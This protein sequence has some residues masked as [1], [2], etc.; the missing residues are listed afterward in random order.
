M[1]GAERWGGGGGCVC[2]CAGGGGSGD[3][4]KAGHRLGFFCRCEFV[5]SLIAFFLVRRAFR[6]L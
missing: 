6:W 2:V 5:G 1:P 3:G 4:W